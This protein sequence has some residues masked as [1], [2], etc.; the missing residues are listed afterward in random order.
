M[1]KSTKKK[2]A[3]IASH[4]MTIRVFLY[5]QIEAL[6]KVYSVDIITNID[7]ETEL[8]HFD[9]QVNIIH[10]RIKRNIDP[11]A[12]ISAFVK[13]TILLKKNHYSLVHSITPKAGLLTMVS[14]RIIGIK[15]RLHTFTGQVWITQQGPMRSLLRFMDKLIAR[16]AT[17]ILVD[18]M[19]QRQFLIKNGIL[20]S[21]S[22]MVL[23]NG[24]ISG[25][26]LKRFHSNAAQH[27]R[28]REQLKLD[29]NTIVLLF[30]GRLKRDKGVVELVEAYIKVRSVLPNIALL[31]VGP[32]EEQLGELLGKM[33]ASAIDLV[34]FIP[35]TNEPEHYMMAA[36]IFCLPSYREGFGSVI[37]EAAACGVPAIGS[38]IYG[39]TDAIIDGVTGLLV[40]TNDISALEQAIVKLATNDELRRQ[41]GEASKKRAQ[42]CFSQERLTKA[43]LDMY[44]NI[45]RES[46]E[47]LM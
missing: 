40:D 37:I 19:S 15:H 35:F 41:Q 38:R 13:L 30:L 46:A 42:N 24:S 11:L 2:I 25:V 34:R 31:L 29:E 8:P 16:F 45:L 10:L 44:H 26:D 36:D 39:V 27:S 22:S 23:A 33:L 5:K 18:S 32:D 1:G 43:L 3:I 20:D 17:N 7:T 12:D 9:D 14:A 4:P 28:I 6:S 47:E 21:R